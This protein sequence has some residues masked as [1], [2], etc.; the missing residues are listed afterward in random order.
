MDI[1]I[2]I[3]AIKLLYES[4]INYNTQVPSCHVITSLC[5]YSS[6][7]EAWKVCVYINGG[8]AAIRGVKES[9]FF[10]AFIEWISTVYYVY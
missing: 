8:A 4:D 9:L 5:G 2:T 3:I 1:I 10:L 6:V 7:S